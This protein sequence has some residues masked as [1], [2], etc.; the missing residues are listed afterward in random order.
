MQGKNMT[1]PLLIRASIQ[2]SLAL[3]HI[4]DDDGRFAW[5][6]CRKGLQEACGVK[7]KSGDRPL[8]KVTVEY[9]EEDID[10]LNR[11]AAGEPQG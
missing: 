3:G 5:V 4:A 7:F 2:Q 1:R 6:M 9:I 11:Q 10:R 8:F